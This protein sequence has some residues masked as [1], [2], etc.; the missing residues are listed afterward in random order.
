MPD[1]NVLFVI[2]DQMRASALG[3]AGND[4][5]HTPNLDRLA[6]SGVRC[7]DACANYPVC[8]PSR[9]CIVSGQYPL[10]TGVVSNDIPLPTDAPS[11]GEAFREAGYRTGYVG[12]WHLDGVP[13]SKFTP[14]GPR[15]QG[16]EDFWAVYNCRHDYWNPAYYRDTPELVE[17]EGYEPAVQTDLALEFIKGDAPFFLT[18]AWGPP[19]DP[20][21]QVPAEY[22]ERYDPADLTLPPNAEPVHPDT[23]AL[24]APPIRHWGTAE[25]FDTGEP[26]AYD[27]RRAV[28]AD[29]YAQITA[30]DDQFGR[31]LDAIGAR[32]DETAVVFTSDHGDML[33]SQGAIQKGSP[34]EESI[35]VP[36]LARWPGGPRGGTS[37]ALVST[38]DFAPTLCGMAGV[39]APD[40]MEGVD[41]SA[42]LAGEERGR[43]SVFLLNVE[44]EWRGVRTRRYTYARLPGEGER[45]QHLPGGHWLLYDNAEDPHQLRNRVLD[46]DDADTRTELSAELD[47]YLDATGDGHRRFE[48]HVREL[49][50]VDRYNEKVTWFKRNHEAYADRR[51]YIGPDLS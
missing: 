1:P 22:R 39:D 9:A 23:D 24:L 3:C 47:A 10:T 36:F 46:A 12:K 21:E 32:D 37:D 2:V 27:D 40:A 41:C 43:E 20:Y 48:D 4:E 6:A 33:F 38:V 25:A 13:R 42:A 34:H 11:V 31:L 16:F 8:T 15:R 45:Y 35:G 30:L 49:G 26:Y 28:L 17:R 50:L 19:H 5:V 14:P 18:L 7:T 44:S 51:D 29:Y